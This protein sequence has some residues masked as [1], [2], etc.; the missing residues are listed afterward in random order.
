MHLGLPLRQ[1]EKGT[2]KSRHAHVPPELS[3]PAISASWLFHQGLLRWIIPLASFLGFA[4]VMISPSLP[5][6]RRRHRARARFTNQDR[7]ARHLARS[8]HLSKHMRH[9]S[10]RT[11]LR[12]FGDLL[13]FLYPQKHGYQLNQRRATQM[14][15]LLTP[16][17][18]GARGPWGEA[19][20]SC[21]C[22]G[23]ASLKGRSLGH[24]SKSRL[25]PVNIPI[26]P[27]LQNMDPSTG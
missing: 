15:A 11:S 27:K 6:E 24:G 14:G 17:G 22:L 25:A 10:L 19:C 16:P 4:P 20:C 8:M 5:I 13:V 7:R 2:L 1:T 21:A 23:S 26:Q 12:L 9:G 3:M 18:S